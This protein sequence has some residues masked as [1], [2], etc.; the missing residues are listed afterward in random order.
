VD[1]LLSDHTKDKDFPAKN[2]NF[3]FKGLWYNTCY[4]NHKRGEKMR[5][6]GEKGAM[7]QIAAMKKITIIK[8]EKIFC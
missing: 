5:K 2:K 8:D 1:Q 4:E 7:V 3:K 6:K